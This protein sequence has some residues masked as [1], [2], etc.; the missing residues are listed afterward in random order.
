MKP[1]NFNYVFTLNELES[2]W[3]GVNLTEIRTDMI[4]IINYMWNNS[5]IVKDVMPILS[6]NVEKFN[7]YKKQYLDLVVASSILMEFFKNI[8]EVEVNNNS[9]NNK[10]NLKNIE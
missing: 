1:E 7:E 5:T 10:N 3:E 6:I 2:E 8:N 9:K 4:N